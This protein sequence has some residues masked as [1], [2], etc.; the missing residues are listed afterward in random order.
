[1]KPKYEKP[2]AMPLGET[3]KGSGQCAV[4]SVAGL[5]ASVNG[6]AIGNVATICSTG[7]SPDWCQSGAVV[8]TYCINGTK[9]ITTSCLEG[10]GPLQ[11][12][13]A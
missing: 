13:P 12:G 11:G 8:G 7:N 2:I 3:V 10:T 4:G 5:T 6:C 1:L 9:G